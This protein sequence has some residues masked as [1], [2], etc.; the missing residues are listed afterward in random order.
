MGNKSIFSINHL[1]H[2]SQDNAVVVD[3]RTV[4][5][6]GGGYTTF[7]SHDDY[8]LFRLL[9]FPCKRALHT[10]LKEHIPP[11]RLSLHTVHMTVQTF[12]HSYTGQNFS[13]E[14]Q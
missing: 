2:K 11:L 12:F 13:E 4:G 7:S 5:G 6:G 8:P 3:F 9:F 1:K 10:N 14:L